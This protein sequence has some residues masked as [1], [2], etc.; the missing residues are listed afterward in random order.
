MLVCFGQVSDSTPSIESIGA[1]ATGALSEAARGESSS[2]TEEQKS[3]LPASAPAAS[4]TAAGA[5]KVLA[6]QS[7]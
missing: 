2:A 5:I 6:A 7:K 1:S 4:Q 3:E